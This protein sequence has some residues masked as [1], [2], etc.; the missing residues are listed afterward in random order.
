MAA[1]FTRLWLKRVPRCTALD[2]T[3]ALLVTPV[4]RGVNA[5]LLI[6]LGAETTLGCARKVVAGRKPLV[7]A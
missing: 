7:R 4:V 2:E 6:P 5:A 3:N 1:V